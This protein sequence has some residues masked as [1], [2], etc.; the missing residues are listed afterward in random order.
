MKK[1]LLL[2]LIVFLFSTI[3]TGCASS[4]TSSKNGEKLYIGLAI[5]GLTNP[6]YVQLIEGAE[7]FIDTLPEGSAELQILSSDGSDEK[8]INE[9]KAFLAK[10]GKNGILYVDPQNAP[11]AAVIAELAEKAGVYWS[12]T[13]SMADGVT[14]KDYKYYVFHQTS[15]DENSGY[16]VAKELI[17]D[18]KTPGKGN[19]LAVQGSLANSASINR[20]NGLKKALREYP[21]VKL[22]D[23]KPADWNAQKALTLTES[24]LSTYKDI[25]A[26]W[27]ANDEMALAVRQALKRAGRNDV[28]V[29]TIDG[30]PDAIKAV[31]NGEL[32]ATVNTNPWAQGGYALAILHAAYTGKLDTSKMT[33][34]QMMFK[35]KGILVTS[36]TIKDYVE[37]YVDQKPKMDFSNIFAPVAGPIN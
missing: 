6:Y 21:N 22:L 11:N 24:W 34:E 8:Q 20:T 35:T 15:D 32:T 1:S 23:M 27:V 7:M 30:I 31:Q 25:D 19:I 33:D 10:A 36:D 3:V 9:I 29:A 28:L 5:R 14:P 18:F 37:N 13:W 26:I 16:L 12:T 17:E 4:E 2:I